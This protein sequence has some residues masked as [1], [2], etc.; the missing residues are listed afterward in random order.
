VSIAAR[1]VLEDAD[2]FWIFQDEIRAINLRRR[3]LNRKREEWGEPLRPELPEDFE[4]AGETIEAV[5]LALSGGGMRSAAVCLG[6]LQA[7]N[8]NR[9]LRNIDYLSTV[10]GGGYIG[11]SLSATMTRSGGEFVFGNEPSNPAGKPLAQEISDT[12][13]VG[14][15]RNY[16]NYLM[17]SGFRDVLTA[18]A[19]VVRGLVANLGL[20]L[21]ALLFSAMLT[22][23]TNPDRSAL[24]RPEV[25]GF[26][27]ERYVLTRHFGVTLMLALI[28]LVF[29]LAWAL[30]RSLLAADK[31][32]EFRTRLPSWGAGVLAVIAITFFLELQPVVVAGMF[33]MADMK[34][35][36]SSG[37]LLGLI[38]SWIQTLAGIAAPVAAA[39][40]VFRQQ[41]GELLKSATAA[42][43]W[44]TQLAALSVKAAVWIAG[45]A[46]PL[47]FWVAYLYLCYWGIINDMPSDPVGPGTHTPWWLLTAAN[48]V[49]KAIWGRVIDRPVALLYLSSGLVLFLLSSLVK[50]NANSLHRLYRD[51]LSKAFLF[52]PTSRLSEKPIPN[53]ASIDQGRDFCALDTIKLSDLSETY[54]PYHLI[55]A[56]LNIQG[57]DY[58]NRRGRNAD[59]FLI[60]KYWIG[61]VATGYAPM[62]EFEPAAGDLDLATA[63]AISGAA[64]S[65]NMGS[66]SVRPLTPTLAIFNIRLGYWM[67][68]PAFWAPTGVV[69]SR[70]QIYPRMWIPKHRSSLFLWSE[71]SGRLYEN[72]DEVYL[73]DGGHIENLGVYELLRRRCRFIIAI[74]VEPDLTMRFPALVRLERFARI[75]LGIRITLPWEAIRKT[76]LALMAVAAGTTL[77]N[78]P[79]PQLGPHAAIG[80]IDYGGGETGYLL[81]LKASLTGDEND[82]IRDYARRYSRFPHESTGDQ[83]F[84]EEQFEVYRALGFHMMHGV[85]CGS[86]R[87]E[88]VGA[89]ADA[90]V[91]FADTSL[92]P[93]RAL[94]SVLM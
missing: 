81:Y 64:V 80:T 77:P 18:A 61:S 91:T 58:A 26:S 33:D 19:I 47:L 17:P 66:Q 72:A 13:A 70:K 86:D 56:T 68:N 2:V 27:V 21:P 50:P 12:E 29:F 20:L 34:A 30:Y 45:C 49:S 87:I 42:S 24:L 15:I 62:E 55:N 88:V 40:T 44:F 67:K 65:S 84:S 60:S 53:E 92:E 8:H 16:S 37:V 48:E 63:M 89:P 4:H 43:G 74:D 9:A 6:A 51:R 1:A 3:A 93:V 36:V 10:S 39:V 71:I 32:S 31:Q 5:G 85:L 7:L 23:W 57:S 78:P 25:F 52:D 59:F 41:F 35:G 28:A 79:S 76:T 94:R 90:V 14:H 22:I 69:S 38:T 46:L 11:C 83:F 54:A 82:Y 75:D 73:T